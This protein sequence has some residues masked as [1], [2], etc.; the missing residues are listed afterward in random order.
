MRIFRKVKAAKGEAE[1]YIR[2]AAQRAP[3]ANAK[4]AEKARFYFPQSLE[5][6]KSLSMVRFETLAM[7]GSR[8][9][10]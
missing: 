2:Y 7:I 8:L 6:L 5:Y 1:A 4:I 10:K 9:L 3:Q